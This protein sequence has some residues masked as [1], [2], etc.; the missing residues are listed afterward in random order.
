MV[1][2]YKKNTKKSVGLKKS[3]ITEGSEASIQQAICNYL[4]AKYP[5]ILY[6]ASAGGMRTSMKQAIKM[7]MTG[8]RKGF[9]DM[10]I[11]KSNDS[12]NG[13][14]IEVKKKGGV[15]SPHQKEWLTR[16][17]DGG[18]FSC[19]VYNLDDAIQII[20]SYI[21]NTIQLSE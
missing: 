2:F 15:I 8:Y 20:E 10:F 7:K 21:S 19:V 14:A 5:R 17:K 6:C 4:D 9:P 3:L 18:Y 1:K 12:F 11:Y 13:L 16:L